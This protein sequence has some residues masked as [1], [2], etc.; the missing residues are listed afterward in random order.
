MACLQFAPYCDWQKHRISLC[1]WGQQIIKAIIPVETRPQWRTLRAESHFKKCCESSP[2]SDQA[3]F[4][5]Y[6]ANRFSCVTVVESRLPNIPP[7]LF[8]ISTTQYSIEPGREK[9]SGLTEVEDIWA[10]MTWRCNYFYFFLPDEN[11]SAALFDDCH[12][13]EAK[14]RPCFAFETFAPHF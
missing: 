10:V 8:N 3:R 6:Q 4:Y 11:A 5:C 12:W 1:F 9:R 2:R 14:S 13:S 7:L